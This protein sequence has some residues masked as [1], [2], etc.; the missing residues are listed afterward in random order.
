MISQ[1]EVIKKHNQLLEQYKN[2]N[3]N[4]GKVNCYRCHV[5]QHITKTIDTDAGVTPMITSCELC[6]NQAWSTGYI[7][8]APAQHPTFEWVRPP[9]SQVIKLMDKPSVLEHIFKGGLML[10]PIPK[11]E[12]PKQKDF[13]E[14]SFDL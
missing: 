10:K 7:D 4:K 1:R 13:I 3:G 14:G 9:L 11:P 6:K 2:E 8:V 5:C 12:P